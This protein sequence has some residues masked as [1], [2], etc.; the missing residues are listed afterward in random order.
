VESFVR[1]WNTRRHRGDA[2]SGLSWARAS[3]AGPSRGRARERHA[4]IRSQRD[5]WWSDGKEAEPDGGSSRSKA[6]R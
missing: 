1:K 6:T 3:F 2:P 4:R 5:S